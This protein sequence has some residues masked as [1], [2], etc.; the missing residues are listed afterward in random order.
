MHT[1]HVY[2][3]VCVCVPAL[4]CTLLKINIKCISSLGPGIESLIKLANGTICT[5]KHDPHGGYR[6]G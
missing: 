4:M 2:V 3:C 5:H 1:V 6:R